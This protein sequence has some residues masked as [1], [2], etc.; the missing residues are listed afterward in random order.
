MK[1][2]VALNSTESIF[3]DFKRKSFV[4]TIA[5]EKY[6]DLEKSLKKKDK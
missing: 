4:D 6:L 2:Y 1:N 3:L 5:L